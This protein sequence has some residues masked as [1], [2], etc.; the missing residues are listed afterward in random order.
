[1][2]RGPKKGTPQKRTPRG[3]SRNSVPAA[4]VGAFREPQN[5][6]LSEASGSSSPDSLG[7]D[8]GGGTN[9]LGGMAGSARGVV[10]RAAAILEQEIAAGIDA[11]KGVERRFVDVEAIRKGNPDELLLRF[12]HDAHEIV[13]I[14]VDLA[15]LA[16]KAVSGVTRG[17]VKVSGQAGNSPREGM[18]APAVATAFPTLAPVSSGRAGTTVELSMSLEN[19]GDV[20]TEEFAFHATD[21]VNFAGK[22]I[23]AEMISSIPKA[24]VIA[25]HSRIDLSINIAVPENTASGVYTGLLQATN[26]GRLRAMLLVPIE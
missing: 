19:D 9:R 2:P 14:L 16:T 11:A 15:I 6:V 8:I 17:V 10:A 22:R 3:S 24:F 7:S 5:P 26:V 1:M 21:L 23:S 13:D 12:R 25:P 18:S 20:P 4:G